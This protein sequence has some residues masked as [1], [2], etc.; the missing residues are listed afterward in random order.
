MGTTETA[1]VVGQ[2]VAAYATTA[3]GGGST[4]VSPNSP[5]PVVV[6]NIARPVTSFV[7]PANVLAY[8]AGQLVANNTVAAS[9]APLQFAVGRN[10]LGLGGQIRRIRMRKT[11]AALTGASFRLHLYTSSPTVSN[12][13][14]GTWLSNQAATYVGSLDVTMDVAFTDGASGNGVPRFGTE[15]NFT[16]NTLYGLLEARGAYAPASGET[17]EV[18]LEV[19]QN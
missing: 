12:G 4:P 3:S 18:E 7:R 11:S 1:P 16:S 14:G 13:D 6:G 2:V 19:T 9:V 8:A 17:I 10:A 5:M 15:I